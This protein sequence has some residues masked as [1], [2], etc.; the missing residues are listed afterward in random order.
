[1][2]PFFAHDDFIPFK[3]L[4]H[5]WSLCLDIGSLPFSFLFLCSPILW[6]VYYA[7][8]RFW[9]NWVIDNCGLYFCF[10]S[11]QDMD[12]D[13]LFCNIFGY[14]LCIQRIHHWTILIHYRYV[15][16]HLNKSFPLSFFLAKIIVFK[17]ININHRKPTST[18]APST[19]WLLLFNC[20]WTSIELIFDSSLVF[21]YVSRRFIF[22]KFQYLFYKTLI[23][24]PQFVNIPHAFTLIFRD[25]KIMLTFIF[26][27]QNPIPI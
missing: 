16:L 22:K 10:V 8:Y 11:L 3:P 26:L 6:Q 19:S 21:N 18:G 2:C 14:N 13:F 17:T 24:L 9:G 1:V 20:G 4:V 23:F 5:I 27:N 15:A 12:S 25:H 7:F